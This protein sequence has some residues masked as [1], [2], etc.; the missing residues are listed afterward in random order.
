MPA[1]A[2]E[3]FAT[4][5]HRLA[6]GEK[7]LV[8][9]EIHAGVFEAFKDVKAA[10]HPDLIADIAG[11]DYVRRGLMA[12]ALFLSWRDRQEGDFLLERVRDHMMEQLRDE[13]TPLPSIYRLGEAL[14]RFCDAWR[15]V[16][17]SGS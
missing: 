5:Y 12:Q 6:P 14:T 1:T 8:N 17:D 16:G 7:D 11:E 3:A 10:A 4:L 2:P 13:R 15:E 9:D